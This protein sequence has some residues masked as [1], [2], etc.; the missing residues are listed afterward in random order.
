MAKRLHQECYSHWHI[1]Q[2]LFLLKT[3]SQQC[4]ATSP[5]S[6]QLMSS[7]GKTKGLIKLGTRDSNLFLQADG[8]GTMLNESNQIKVYWQKKG[9]YKLRAM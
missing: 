9:G 6:I 1:W 5:F 2:G 4:I 3:G 7:K 8:T